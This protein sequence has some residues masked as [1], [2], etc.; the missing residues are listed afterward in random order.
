MTSQ[1]REHLV[2]T[3]VAH[4]YDAAAQFAIQNGSSPKIIRKL[5]SRRGIPNTT[6]RGPK[7]GTKYVRVKVDP[8]WHRAIAVGMVIA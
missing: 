1:Q 5:L 6:K 2:A 3:Y 4:G 7:P 8:R